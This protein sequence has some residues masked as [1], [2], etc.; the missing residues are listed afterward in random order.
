[1]CVTGV[2]VKTNPWPSLQLHWKHKLA[3]IET[4]V[5]VTLHKLGS[6]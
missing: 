2:E 4:S 1:M 6:V 5:G 3:Q